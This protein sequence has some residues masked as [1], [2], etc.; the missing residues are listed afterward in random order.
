MRKDH[1]QKF[2]DC[3][4]QLVHGKAAE[5]E[6]RL[7]ASRPDRMLPEWL[8]RFC[9]ETPFSPESAP[10]FRKEV[11]KSLGAAQGRDYANAPCA[12]YEQ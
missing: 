4:Y 2:A 1:S 8:C 7:C 10:G 6:K 12:G 5:L 3:G 9:G 11:T